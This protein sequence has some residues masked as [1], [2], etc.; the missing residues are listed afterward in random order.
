MTVACAALPGQLQTGAMLTNRDEELIIGCGLYLPRHWL[1]NARL[2]LV[3]TGT[4]EG[5]L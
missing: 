4:A 5:H 3:D 1:V 2:S